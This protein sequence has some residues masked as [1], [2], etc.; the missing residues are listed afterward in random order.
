MATA[1]RWPSRETEKLKAYIT[2]EELRLKTDF[3]KLEKWEFAV[4][5]RERT[6]C[7]GKA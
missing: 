3:S 7:N 5:M 1:R 4:K 2:V 6:V